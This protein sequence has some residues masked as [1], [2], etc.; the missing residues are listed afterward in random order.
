MAEPVTQR[1]S[2]EEYLAQ[3]RRSEIRHEYLDGEVFAMTGASVRHNRIVLDT[4]ASLQK[5][6]AGSDCEAFASDLRVK[7]SASGLY[8]YPDLVVV[9]GELEL[10]DE[11]V[12]T[13][14]NPTLIVEVLSPSTA[15]YD[16]GGKF[17]HYRSIPSLQEYLVLAQDR[18]HA[19]H[20]RRQEGNWV[21]AE[22]DDRQAV[23]ELAAIG[24][25]LPLAEVYER[26]LPAE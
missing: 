25:Q 21:L 5:R 20:Y 12:D 8:T 17:A 22:T 13:L 24:C 14:L 9:C 1:V 7:V 6:L 26:A 3:E 11:H 18:V 19:E 4:G 15:D 2:V 10:E 23:L 16:R